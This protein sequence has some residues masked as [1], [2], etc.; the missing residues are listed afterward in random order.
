MFRTHSPS[1]T[2]ELTAVVA[3]AATAEM[4]AFLDER[5]ANLARAAGATDA[6]A[7]LR[8]ALTVSGILGLT[9]A[10][11]FL[12]LET[13]ADVSAEHLADVTRPWLAASLRP[14]IP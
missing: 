12:G 14:A 8:A 5:V 6:D 13:L 11:H 2:A 9:I 1:C 7:E 3:P 10:R 4:K